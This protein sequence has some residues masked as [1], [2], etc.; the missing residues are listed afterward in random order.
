MAL[1]YADENFNLR[2]V[3]ELRRLG[4]DI[5]TAQQAGQAQRGIADP[6]VLSFATARNRAV[7]TFNTF[8]SVRLHQQHILS[9]TPH[10]GIIVCTQD[11]D[12]QAL[13]QRIHLAIAA[14]PSLANQLVRIRKP[15]SAASS[16]SVP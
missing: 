3:E 15:P 14:L 4:H 16:P 11:G 9:S 10:A 13:A 7:L 6:L 1:L 8:H 12:R 2:V 5:L